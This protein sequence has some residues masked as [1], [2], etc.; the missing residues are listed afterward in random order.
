MGNMAFC[1]CQPYILREEVCLVLDWVGTCAEP[2]PPLAVS[3]CRG[4]VA[5]G[6]GFIFMAPF[7]VKGSELY[8]PVAHDIRIGGESC[9]DLVHRVACHLVPILTVAVDNLKSAA[10]FTA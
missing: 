9:A 10:V 7:L 6:Y 8:Q 2:F 1:S 5:C 3:L 4:I